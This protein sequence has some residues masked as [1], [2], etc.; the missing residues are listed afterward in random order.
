[1]TKVKRHSSILKKKKGKN[2]KKNDSLE[3]LQKNITIEFIDK[4]K[5]NF[6]S[7]KE[8]IISR[9][10]I[11]AVGS[12]LATTNSEEV[13]KIDHF[14]LNT[15]KKKD[16][17]ATNQGHSGRCWMFAGLNMFRH[18]VIRALNL[19]NFEF[20]E[21]YLFF[22][23]KFERAN[24]YISWFIENSDKTPNDREFQFMTQE[25]RGDGGWW[26]FFSSI[27][28]KYKLIPK[29]AM[30][31]TWQSADTDDMNNILDDI[32]QSC[33]NYLYNNSS[34]LSIN[35]KI[36][37]KNNTLKE[38]YNTLVKFL[39]EPPKTFNWSY[40][41]EDEDTA[42]FSEMTPELYK[43]LMLPEINLKDFVVLSNFPHLKYNQ[44]YEIKQVKNVTEG[45]SCTF[46]NVNINEMEKYTMKSILAG[47]P[48]W[49]AADIT[50]DFNMYHSTLDDKI[51]DKNKV[52]NNIYNF[53]KSDKVIFSNLSTNHAM[54]IVGLNIANNK[55]IN[56]QVEN[57]WGYWDN[58]T[59]GADGFLYMS[60]SW[61]NKN[62][63]EVVIHK[64]FLSRTLSKILS[65]NPIYMN[66]W[67]SVSSALKIKPSDAPK[68]YKDIGK[69]ILKK[70]NNYN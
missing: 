17:K 12:M 8:N 70:Y 41:S 65:E 61:F 59:P 56:W 51:T 52:F 46:L 10:A 49:F 7:K 55:P 47:I 26:N 6:H 42:I 43:N 24:Y 67:D 45:E 48:V 15:L 23:D 30:N 31:E 2:I 22:W 60:N 9:N 39:G 20:S 36:E 37:H 62:V 40:I 63:M 18:N 32:V 25:Y 54:T 38:V 66:P 29:S 69:Y 64:K 34:T 57:S 5:D 50:K 33:S 28:E 53:K 68:K 14:F 13:N 44:T 19:E 3:Y 58:E 1:M 35:E 27:V 11:V 21:T 16:L 4:C